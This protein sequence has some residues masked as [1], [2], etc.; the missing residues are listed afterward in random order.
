MAEP[1][2]KSGQ[3]IDVQSLSAGCEKNQ[4]ISLVKTHDFEIIQFIVPADKGIPPYEAQGELI[5]TCL[6]GRVSVTVHGSAHHLTS[7]QLLHLPRNEPF[8]IQAAEDTSLLATIVF[9][10]QGRNVDMIGED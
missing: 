4:K 6:E 3:T 9:P 2:A 7:G 5:L 10:K 8:S 1:L